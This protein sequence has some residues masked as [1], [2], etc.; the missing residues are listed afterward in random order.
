VVWEIALVI[1]IN[2]ITYKC[3]H[4]NMFIYIYISPHDVLWNPRVLGNPV[5]NG[6]SRHLKQL[7]L[8]YDL[9]VRGLKH[10]LHSP[11]PNTTSSKHE[12]V[13]T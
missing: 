3:K 10:T 8:W 12:P 13:T 11:S 4:E 7:V 1:I 2:I 5:E 9:A 6:R